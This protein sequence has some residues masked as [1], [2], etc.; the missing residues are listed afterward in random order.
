MSTRKH[1]DFDLVAN[2]DDFFGVFDLVVGQ[3]A[4]VQ[5]AFQ[6]IFQS[7]EDT[8]V[9]DLGDLTFDQLARLILVRNVAIPWIVVELLQSQRDAAT[10]FVDAQARGT[11][12]LGPFPALRWDD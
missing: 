5:Q 11:R 3:F 4:D 6:A 12:S 10:V 1:F 2:F 8:E 9:G 7:D